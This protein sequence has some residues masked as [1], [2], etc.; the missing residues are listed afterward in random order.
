MVVLAGAVVVSGRRTFFSL[1]YLKSQKNERSKHELLRVYHEEYL[2]YGEESCRVCFWHFSL[3]FRFFN[4]FIQSK[5]N[6]REL[7]LKIHTHTQ[8]Q[9]SCC[10]ICWASCRQAKVALPVSTNCIFIIKPQKSQMWC[11]NPFIAISKSYSFISNSQFVL[12]IHV[13]S[14]FCTKYSCSLSLGFHRSF[15]FPPI[16]PYYLRLGACLFSRPLFN[17]SKEDSVVRVKDMKLKT[18]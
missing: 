2:C 16:Y 8:I 6:S 12:V 1:R 15:L 14:I 7:V 3:L 5:S 10:E 11:Q 13:H 18:K 4:L 17:L 9:M